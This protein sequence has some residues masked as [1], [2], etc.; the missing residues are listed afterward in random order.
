[1]KCPF[2]NNL[3]TQV[4]DTRASDDQM[5]IKRRRRCGN[6]ER[7]FNT[8]E[9]MEL[10]MPLIM[11]SD[12]SREEYNEQ[13]VKNSLLKALHKR[14]ISAKT[15]DEAIDNVRKNMLLQNE[16]EVN[17][18]QI[19]QFVLDELIKIDNIAYV[20]FASIYLSFKDIKDFANIIQQ[21]DKKKEK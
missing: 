16:R 7:R 3:E 13:K 15:I 17:A 20:R 6:C 18:S 21:V 19:G 9:K 5:S 10:D 8:F 12:G 14:P 2:C 1:M 11:K 4:I